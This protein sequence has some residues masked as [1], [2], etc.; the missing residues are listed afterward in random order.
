MHAEVEDIMEDVSVLFI[1][2][3]F[4][5]GYFLMDDGWTSKWHAWREK[6]S[7]ILTYL[8]VRK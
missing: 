4:V 6:T 7:F 1:I 5:F 2:V 8:E 3:K